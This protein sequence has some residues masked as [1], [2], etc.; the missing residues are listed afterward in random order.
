VS[1]GGRSGLVLYAVAFVLMLAALGSL[2]SA[3]HGFLQE[4][5]PLWLSA[6]L[7]VAAILLAIAA[8]VVDRRRP[9]APGSAT[10][11]S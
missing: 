10:A 4:R 11:R 1:A 8:W 7:S 2:L 5:W 3:I 9:D 6:G